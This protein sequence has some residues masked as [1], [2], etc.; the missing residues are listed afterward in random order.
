M[1]EEESKQPFPGG[2]L[3]QTGG[4]IVGEES[5]ALENG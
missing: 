1:G 5:Q 2:L 3:A 4:W